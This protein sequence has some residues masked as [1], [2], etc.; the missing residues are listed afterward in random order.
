MLETYFFDLSSLANEFSFSL[1][2]F[3]YAAILGLALFITIYV[4]R[5]NINDK[6]VSK[7]I[8][9]IYDGL[10]LKKSSL[11]QPEWFIFRRITFAA[12]AIYGTG[13]LWI[14]FLFLFNTSFVTF[15]IINRRLHELRL[16]H[17]MEVV[18]EAFV[19]IV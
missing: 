12:C 15:G 3:L 7:R 1:A 11:I 17:I 13:Y 10:I 16:V 14:Q 6:N 18:N 8:G 9:T 5:V 2:I 4:R 19:L